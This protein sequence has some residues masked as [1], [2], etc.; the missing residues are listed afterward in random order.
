MASIVSRERIEYRFQQGLRHLIGRPNSDVDE[1][2]KAL[3][4]PMQWHYMERLSPADRAHLL[5]VHCELARQGFTNHDLLLAAL[6]HDIGKADDRGQVTVVHRAIKVLLRKIAPGRLDRIARVGGGWLSHGMYLAL[7][8][9]ALGAELAR[10]SGANER[11]CW[12]IAHH[13]NG[14]ISGDSELLALQI[15]DAK[16]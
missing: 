1:A 10:Q 13:D 7:N 2:L 8:H 15:I 4:S 9:A 6:L 3:L 11:T 14:T 16:E 12:F 5:K